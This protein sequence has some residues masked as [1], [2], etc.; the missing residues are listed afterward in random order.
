MDQSLKLPGMKVSRKAFL[1]EVFQ[2]YG[3]ITRIENKRPA[4]LFDEE[5]I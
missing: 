3:D 2:N 4:D 5:I 1:S